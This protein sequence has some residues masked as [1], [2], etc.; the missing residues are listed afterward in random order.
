MQWVLILIDCLSDN[1][2]RYSFIHIKCR[3]HDIIR[4]NK[5][6]NTFEI[7]V[8]DIIE[9]HAYHAYLKKETKQEKLIGY[10]TLNQ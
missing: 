5:Q 10:S 9:K 1:F 8:A 3:T 6:R 7:N 4:K 2:V